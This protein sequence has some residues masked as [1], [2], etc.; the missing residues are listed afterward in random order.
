MANKLGKALEL[1]LDLGVNAIA[2]EEG[3]LSSVHAVIIFA[4]FLCSSSRI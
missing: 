2:M 4:F 3:A 1:L